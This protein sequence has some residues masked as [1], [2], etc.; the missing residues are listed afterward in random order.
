MTALSENFNE[1]STQDLKGRRERAVRGL[2]GDRLEL[3]TGFVDLADQEESSRREEAVAKRDAR[4]AAN[5]NSLWGQVGLVPGGISAH[6][7]IQI[8]E[9]K[10]MSARGAKD[11]LSLDQVT[12]QSLREDYILR[13][14]AMTQRYEQQQNEAHAD[15]R[16]ANEIRHAENLLGL[17]DEEIAHHIEHRSEVE[18]DRETPETSREDRSFEKGDLSREFDRRR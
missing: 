14:F 18:Q 8:G 6:D 15:L 11:N 7:P 16:L 12:P 13:G 4:T 1:I 17:T 2:S 10:E 9:V 5:A 3:F